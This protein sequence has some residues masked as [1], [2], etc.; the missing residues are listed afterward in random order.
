MKIA[1]RGAAD[2]LFNCEA[3]MCKYVFLHFIYD[4]AVRGVWLS[5]G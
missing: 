5:E 4:F 1:Q 3:E 2:L